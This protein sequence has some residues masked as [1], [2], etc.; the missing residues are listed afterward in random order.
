MRA[1]QS[2]GSKLCCNSTHKP[3][4][5]LQSKIACE[6]WSIIGAPI[7]EKS[8]PNTCAKRET[9]SFMG[10]LMQQVS[11]R[12]DVT[13]EKDGILISRNGKQGSD[14]IDEALKYNGQ[15][16]AS[17]TPSAPVQRSMPKTMPTTPPQTQKAAACQKFRRLQ[18][19]L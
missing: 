7:P 19:R 2:S 4:F 6:K 11:G 10:N 17:T 13:V 8:T 14:L 18:L 1:R 5:V 12:A 3:S 15:L 9:Q 16:P